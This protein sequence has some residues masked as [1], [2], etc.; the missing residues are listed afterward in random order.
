MVDIWKRLK[1]KW[2]RIRRIG[3]SPIVTP[4]PPPRKR[5]VKTLKPISDRVYKKAGVRRLPKQDKGD[6][7]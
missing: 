7:A 5:K 3:V 2:T 4:P 1:R 6:K